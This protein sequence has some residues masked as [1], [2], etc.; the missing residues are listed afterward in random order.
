MNHKNTF[1]A[2]LLLAF[3]VLFAALA[4]QGADAKAFGGLAL[5]CLLV[6]G[7]VK[8]ILYFAIQAEQNSLKDVKYFETRKED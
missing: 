2:N 3:V 6:L 1:F 7:I 8:T 5:F 4:S